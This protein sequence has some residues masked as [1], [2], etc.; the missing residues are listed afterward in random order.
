M[1]LLL[2]M[3][4]TMTTHA[5]VVDTINYGVKLSHTPSNI[6]RGPEKKFPTESKKLIRIAIIDTGYS[7]TKASFPI[8]LCDSGHYDFAK[9]KPTV[10]FGVDHGSQVASIIASDLN[11]VNYCAVIYNVWQNNTVPFENIVDAFRMIEKEDI[12]AVNI[13]LQ[14]VNYSY[15]ERKAIEEVVAKGTQVFVAAGNSNLD[16][17]AM[18][19]SFPGCYQIKG[20]HTVGALTPDYQQKA[21]YSNYGAKVE[22]WYPGDYQTLLDYAQ[23]TSFASPRALANYVLALSKQK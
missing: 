3:L 20:L 5:Q 19:N 11:G 9:N 1:K 7:K 12:A 10:G 17:D 23:G 21:S 18:C 22:L 2:F 4:V 8:K 15:S 6:M 14:G 16:L 13:S